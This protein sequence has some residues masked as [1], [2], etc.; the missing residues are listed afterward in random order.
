MQMELWYLISAHRLTM[1]YICTKF[2]ENNQTVSEFL[3]D[4]ICI[5]KFA[6]GHNSIILYKVL[7]ELWHLV[8]LHRLIMLY[9]GTGQSR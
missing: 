9:I 3:A 6:K 8:C 1:L 7:V 4:V 5:L 2:R